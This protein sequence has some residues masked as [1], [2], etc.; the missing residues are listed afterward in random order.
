[1]N[2]RIFFWICSFSIAFSCGGE[3]EASQ[4][5]KGIE[6]AIDAA[7][8]RYSKDVRVSE[9]LLTEIKNSSKILDANS[10]IIDTLFMSIH[11]SVHNGFVLM[12]KFESENKNILK[13]FVFDR[14]I[15]GKLVRK[16]IFD[17]ILLGKD[18][19]VSDYPRIMMRF[20][21]FYGKTERYYYNC[22]FTFDHSLDKYIFEHCLSINKKG[23]GDSYF[24]VYISKAES[25]A[26]QLITDKEVFSVLEKNN[27][28]N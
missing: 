19:L 15:E 7:A 3:N 22:W 11:D 8:N 13:T 26:N 24:D 9:N 25:P 4:N 28:L 16:N 12:C 14:N 21:E 5:N 18:T 17:G 2:T 10:N 1:M 27:Y 20:V 6:T 23:K